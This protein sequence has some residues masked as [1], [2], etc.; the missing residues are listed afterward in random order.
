MT[1]LLIGESTYVLELW[2]GHKWIFILCNP[3]LWMWH[4][5]QL[6]QLHGEIVLY[7]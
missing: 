5:G 6:P 7:V 4:V 3:H 2:V 1:N